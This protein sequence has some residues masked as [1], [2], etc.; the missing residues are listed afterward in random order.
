MR[1]QGGPAR[2][3][4]VDSDRQAERQAG[5]EA[6]I[7]GRKHPRKQGRSE[8]ATTA[9]VAARGVEATYELE[10]VEL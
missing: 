3:T 8:G 6:A 5:R 1:E 4:T 7:A 9:L 2:W 10:G